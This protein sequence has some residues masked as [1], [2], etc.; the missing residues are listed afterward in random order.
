MEAK[1]AQRGGFLGKKGGFR[2]A[3]AQ[4]RGRRDFFCLLVLC[5]LIV[6]EI[7]AAGKPLMHKGF[8]PVFGAVATLNPR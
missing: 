6:T 4:D 2:R 8:S 3:P 1:R 5:Y 7:L